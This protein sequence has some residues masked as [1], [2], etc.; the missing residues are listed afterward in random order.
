[1]IA[2]SVEEGQKVQDN[3]IDGTFGMLKSIATRDSCKLVCHEYFA[4]GFTFELMIEI[5]KISQ[6]YPI[7]SL[8]KTTLNIVCAFFFFPKT[9]NFITIEVVNYDCV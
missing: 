9:T 7:S 3:W 6:K 5:T 2:L 8:I 1:M 4:W